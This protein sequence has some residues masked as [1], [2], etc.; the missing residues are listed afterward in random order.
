MMTGHVVQRHALLPVTFRLP[1]QRDIAIEFVVDTGFSGALTLPLAAVQAMQLT[2]EEDILAN[3]ATDEEVQTPVY[4]AT[5]LWDGSE[6]DVRVLAIGKRPLLGTALLHSHELLVQFADN[7]LVRL[8]VNPPRVNPGV[9]HEG[10]KIP[11]FGALRADRPT[12]G[13]TR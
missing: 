2:Y 4:A 8:G 1:N 7:G 11:R 10:C 13:N 5:I 6:R 3:V 9:L 12:D